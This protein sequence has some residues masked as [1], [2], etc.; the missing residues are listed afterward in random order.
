MSCGG[1]ADSFQ[2]KID[3]DFSDHFNGLAV[4]E[5]WLV[6]PLPYRIDRSRHQARIDELVYGFQLCDRALGRNDGPKQ[7]GSLD[8]FSLAAGRVCGIH[9]IG[10]LCMLNVATHPDPL[11]GTIRNAAYNR[12]VGLVGGDRDGFMDFPRLEHDFERRRLTVFDHE[13]SQYQQRKAWFS[14]LEPVF[15]V[16]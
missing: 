8:T 11:R 3:I 9:L 6:A 5:S 10:Q 16:G 7:N 14:H 12:A 1:G 13:P 4:Q 15:A 2:D